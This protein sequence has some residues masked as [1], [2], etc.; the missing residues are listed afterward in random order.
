M[1]RIYNTS[2]V[3]LITSIAENFPNV[4]IEAMACGIPVVG[5]STGGIKDQI[6]HKENGWVVKPRDVD[7]LLEGV[8][9]ILNEADYRSLSYHARTYVET[10]CSYRNILENH[11]C[12]LEYGKNKE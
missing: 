3:L 11:K 9:W 4:V 7:G 5:F 6:Q 2:D 10:Y 12:I 8:N 1:V